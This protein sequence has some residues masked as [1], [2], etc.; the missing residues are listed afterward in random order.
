MPTHK[1]TPAFHERAAHIAERAMPV[2]K[3][4]AKL[5]PMIY[6]NVNT[7]FERILKMRKIIA[8]LIV[9]VLIFSMSSV[10]FAGYH[11]YSGGANNYFDTRSLDRVGTATERDSPY[12]SPHK[13]KVVS[14]STA[15][16]NELTVWGGDS[17]TLTFKSGANNYSSA[18]L[19][20][21]AI[22]SYGYFYAVGKFYA[23]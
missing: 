22:S 19:R 20:L 18:K 17:V 9:A 8:F 5:Y 7:V 2:C 23:A 1:N 6:K 21:S 14:G 16:S 10:A 12:A 15:L 11:E 3:G 13:S 4:M